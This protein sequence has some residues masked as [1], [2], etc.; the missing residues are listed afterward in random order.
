MQVLPLLTPNQYNAK[1][2]MRSTTDDF[3]SHCFKKRLISTQ[4]DFLPK[5]KLPLKDTLH[6][7]DV[8]GTWLPMEQ[9]AGSSR[10]TIPHFI[11]SNSS[12]E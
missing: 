4:T 2:R 6:M 5:P 10:Y 9:K 11:L 1:K 8:N 7:V 12:S 3:E